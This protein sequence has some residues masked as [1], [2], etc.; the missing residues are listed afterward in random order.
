[1][2]ETCLIE[3]TVV[4]TRHAY[5]DLA[6]GVRQA[7]SRLTVCLC[8]AFRAAPRETQS[9]ETAGASS[10]QMSR[11]AKY[12]SPITATTNDRPADQPASSPIN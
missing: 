12:A 4:R 5:T 11:R 10:P 8:F 1:M 6:K 2:R 7:W 3:R 9:K